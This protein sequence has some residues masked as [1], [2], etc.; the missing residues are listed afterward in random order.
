MNDVQNFLMY[1]LKYLM[2]FLFYVIDY[3]MNLFVVTKVLYFQ[4]N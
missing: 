1:E 2:E 3:K 4:Y